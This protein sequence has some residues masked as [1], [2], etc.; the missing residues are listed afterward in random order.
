MKASPE[1]RIADY[2][3]VSITNLVGEVYL[4]RLHAPE[5]AGAL[6]PGQ[7]VNIRVHDEFIP[8]L[9]K[10]FSVCRRSVEEGWIEVLWKIVG[11]GTKIMSGYVPGQRVNLMGTLGQGYK[12]LPNLGEAILVG[13]GLGVAPLPFLC[14]EL[15]KTGAS[16]AVFLGARSADEL[17]MVEAFTC[18]GVDVHT[19]TEDGSAGQRG[20][21]TEI[22]TPYLEWRI[23]NPDVHLYSCGPMGLLRAMIEISERYRIGGQI[24]LETMMGCGFGICMGCPI[25]VREGRPGGL[26]KLACLDGPVFDAGEV[27]L[28]D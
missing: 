23:G 25:R 10:P 28:D 14:E 17:A 27:W 8:L 7:F 20:L 13:G 9:R 26:Y 11:K 1:K 6:V 24:S 3:V 19:A 2:P 21:V 18:L 22:L 16:V 12:M 5:L 4:M 15:V